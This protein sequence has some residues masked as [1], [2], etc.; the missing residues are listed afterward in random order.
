MLKRIF[1]V[2]MVL[3][4]KQH[5][6]TSNCCMFQ[7]VFVQMWTSHTVSELNMPAITLIGKYHNIK[8]V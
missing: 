5:M 3:S 2:C 8:A 7:A 6:Y 4:F 1:C